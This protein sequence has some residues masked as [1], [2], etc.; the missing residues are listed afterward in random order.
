[1]KQNIKSVKI[2]K[3]QNGA[4]N[5]YYMNEEDII[6]NLNKDDKF[7]LKTT[8]MK[9]N[10]KDPK[11]GDKYLKHL[12][13]KSIRISFANLFKPSVRFQT[14]K[15]LF[16]K[17]KFNRNF[18]ILKKRIGRN[19]QFN[20]G[21]CVDFNRMAQTPNPSNLVTTRVNFAASA[22]VVK[23]NQPQFQALDTCFDGNFL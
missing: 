11:L 3:A 8:K 19:Q 15:K 2:A 5:H 10:T 23:F 4:N 1:M 21:K 13:L 18:L 22:R 17:T 6:T 9:R 20:E 14:N 16:F 7:G 12:T